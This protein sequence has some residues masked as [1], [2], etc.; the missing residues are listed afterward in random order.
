MNSDPEI[1]TFFIVGN[2]HAFTTTESVLPNLKLTTEHLKL[3]SVDL[4]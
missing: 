1:K 4:E 2:L 3:F